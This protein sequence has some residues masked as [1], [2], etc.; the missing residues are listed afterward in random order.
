MHVDPLRVN[1]RQLIE[2]SGQRSSS[3][4]EVVPLKHGH[5]MNIAYVEAADR[6]TAA[7]KIQ[8]IFRSF[9]E[10]RFAEL[11]AK[12]Q[13]FFEAKAIAVQEM[14]DA[15]VLEFRTREA[16]T[17]MGRMKWDGKCNN[18]LYKRIAL[19]FVV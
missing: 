16:S 15:L 2:K 17:G 18:H 8:S 7:I 10:R 12:Q 9:K 6:N 19:N 3:Y 11:A 1:Y 13:A 4:I 5:L 14:K